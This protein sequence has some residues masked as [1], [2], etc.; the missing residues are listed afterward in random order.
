MKKIWLLLVLLLVVGCEEVVREVSWDSYSNDQGFSIDHP[1]WNGTD[2]ANESVVSIAEAGCMVAVNKYDGSSDIMYDWLSMYL[3]E[4]DL[5]ITSM[6]GETKEIEYAAYHDIYLFYSKLK[7]YDCNG[8]AYNVLLACEQSLFNESEYSRLFDS[9]SCDEEMKEEQDYVSYSDE[10][11][12]VNFPDWDITEQNDALVMNDAFCN[13]YLFE[14][15]AGVEEVQNWLIASLDDYAMRDG[16][17][18]YNTD[19]NGTILKSRAGFNYCNYQTYVVVYTCVESVFDEDVSDEVLSSLECAEVYEEIEEE[20]PEEIEEIVEEVEEVKE[21]IV[22]LVL[23]EK[24]GLI[25]PEWIVW[26]INS[27]DFFTYIL[28]DY[29]RVNLVLEDDVNFNIKA[30]L[31]GGEIVHIEEGLHADGVS[32]FIPAGDAVEILNNMDNINF[33]NFLVFAAKVRTEPVE[34]KQDV[35]NKILG[36]E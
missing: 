24:Y 12:G 28:E 23:P 7:I 3:E 15:S 25:D 20:E 11:M 6:D 27:N 16:F 30:D 13:V 8:Y 22:G 34:V 33:V 35:I 31:V 14:N 9:V 10:D 29:D 4:Q 21:E 1:D 18:E 19:Y 36:I 2:G 17:L 32:V 5:D 26:F